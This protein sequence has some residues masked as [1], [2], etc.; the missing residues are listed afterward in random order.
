MEDE[1]PQPHAHPL[2]TVGGTGVSIRPMTIDDIPAIFHLG[3]VLFTARIAPN[4]HRTW[5][6]YEVVGFF[7]TDC[8]FC[9]VA[10]DEN[11]G[12]IGFALGTIIEK[13]HSWTYGYLI[14]LG[15]RADYQ[16]SG[17]AQRLFR[18]FKNAM[19]DAGARIIMVDTDAENHA[20]LRFFRKM[21]F[22]HSRQHVYLTLNVDDDR[23]KHEER[24]KERIIRY[25]VDDHEKE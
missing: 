6:E 4:A 11:K 16:Q 22:D 1:N 20:S 18:H 17:I 13:H 19:I 7:Q 21:G 5:D 2:E 25:T 3:E 24:R 23:R 15:V 14:W 8:E 10:E 9:F 12:V